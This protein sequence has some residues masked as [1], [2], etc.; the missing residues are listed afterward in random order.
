MGID[1]SRTTKTDQ[2]ILI[3][4]A[5]GKTG[6][7]L[8]AALPRS[9]GVCAFVHREDQV[10]AMKGLGA[11]QIVL[12]DLR[13][14]T[15]LR[16]AM[17][18]VRALY[19]ICP[20]MSPDERLIG[21]GVIE[22]ARTAGVE[23]LVYHSVLHTQTERMPHHWGK[24]QVEAMLFESGLRYT[25]LQPAPYMQNLLSGWKNILEKSVLFVPF[26]IHAQFSFVDLGDVAR[27][28]AIVLTE[29]GH[30]RATYELAG[31][32]PLS[33]VEAARILTGVLNRS[34]RAEQEAIGDWEQRARV[35]G[36]SEYALE[37][38]IKMFNY[39]DQWGLP[40]NPNV[41]RWLLGHE[42]R[43]LEMFFGKMLQEREVGNVH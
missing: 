10:S 26:S 2:M 11:Q 38:L 20:N 19:H 35:A 3:T 1:G 5:G 25:I 7:S 21:R 33:H 36:V 39:Y 12:G 41:M 4:G 34:V 6:R 14:E 40:G 22:A 29:P 24:L 16:K 30:D 37:N 31:P 32:A 43:T 13:D 8:I 28:A 9:E 15:A 17:Q 27:A 23:H 18:G 42:P